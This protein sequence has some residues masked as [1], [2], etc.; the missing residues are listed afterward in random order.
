MTETNEDFP[1]VTSGKGKR[2]LAL[3]GRA[4]AIA[5][6]GAVAFS[7]VFSSGK[8][9]DSGACASSREEIDALTSL[10]RGEVAAFS[11]APKRKPFPALSFEGADG[12]PLTLDDFKGKTVLLNLWATWCA[13]CRLE[14]PALDRLQRELGGTNF[15]VVAI[16][17]DTSG[18]DRPRKWLK[19]NGI[20]TLAFHA[21][22]KGG[23]FKTLQKSG[24][25]VGLPTTVLIDA[26]GCEAGILKGAADWASDDAFKLLRAARDSH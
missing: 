16:N 18:G 6:I 15:E 19:E 23:V 21:D 4:L 12:R 25:A 5:V 3:A 26:R 22:P 17:L 24:H 7:G 13:P 8:M 9:G 1:R 2:Y 10:A 20:E 14:M 11:V